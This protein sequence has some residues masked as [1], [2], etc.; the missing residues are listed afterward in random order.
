MS[1]TFAEATKTS[2]PVIVLD[3]SALEDWCDAQPQRVRNWVMSSKF[4][5]G[6][7][8]AL[9]VPSDRGDPQC[10]LIGYGSA[11]KRKR[12]RFALADAVGKLP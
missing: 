5:A 10:A 1:L 8:Q 9:L 12:S 7:G 2:I 11:S 3:T 6:L 4:T